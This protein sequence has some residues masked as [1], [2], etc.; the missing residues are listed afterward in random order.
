[1]DDEGKPFTPSDD[2]LLE[3]FSAKLKGVKLGDTDG[4]REH[5]KDVLCNARVFGVD[6]Y[7]AGLG[8]RV[9]NYFG[10]LIAGPGAVRKTLHKYAT[11]L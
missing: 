6:L 4:Y 8:E 3:E 7:E 5:L 2:P 11:E 10:E 9:E 1:V